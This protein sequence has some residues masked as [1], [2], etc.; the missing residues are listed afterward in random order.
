MFFI[1]IFGIQD[2]QKEVCDIKIECKNCN[3]RHIKL[4][5]TFRYFHIFFLPIYKWKNRYH[6]FCDNCGIVYSIPEEKGMKAEKGE[7]D[8]IIY[9]DLEEVHKKPI[10]K[11]CPNCNNQ[12]DDNFEYCPYCGKKL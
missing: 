3:S 1:G 8:V 12:V 10:V 6:A 11:R 7:S 5:K 2:K 4:Y 9:W